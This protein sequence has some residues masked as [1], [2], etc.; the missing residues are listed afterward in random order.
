MIEN[1]WLATPTDMISIGRKLDFLNGKAS[2]RKFSLF[3]LAC[4]RA[5]W[6]LL[7]HEHY[8]RAIETAE[9]VVEDQSTKEDLESALILANNAIFAVQ[10]SQVGDAF[11]TREMMAATAAVHAAELDFRSLSFPDDASYARGVAHEVT[12]AA[13]WAAATDAC[14][15]SESTSA[16]LGWADVWHQAQESQLAGIGVLLLDV[17]GNPFRPVAVPTTPEA[18]I[19][20]ATAEAIYR[21]SAFDRL[22]ELAD[23]LEDAGCQDA[24]ILEHCRRPG[25]HVRGCWV[26][27]LILGKD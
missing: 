13:C 27:D 20:P 14:G 16:S 3:R 1:E 18:S 6:H 8:R 11:R 19:V 17:F 24:E 10:Q 2:T 26:V 22:P 21:D 5:I 15:S 4:C 9:R 25:V 12:S 23:A 7:G